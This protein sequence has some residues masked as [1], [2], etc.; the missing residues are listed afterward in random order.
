[1]RHDTTAGVRPTRATARTTLVGTPKSI[2]AGSFSGPRK[3][4]PDIE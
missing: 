4:R 1:M 2:R 3:R